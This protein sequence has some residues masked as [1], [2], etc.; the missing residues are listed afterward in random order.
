MKFKYFLVILSGL[1]CYLVQ[2]DQTCGKKPESVGKTLIGQELASNSWPWVVALI[3]RQNL[4]F[5]CGGTLISS[6]HVLTGEHFFVSQLISS[7]LD[8]PQFCYSQLRIASTR[9]T[10]RLSKQLTKSQL[11]LA[12]TT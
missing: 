7:F 10:D 6:R 2:T 12:D 8:L 3:N 4:Q 9:N 5:F 1:A 11:L